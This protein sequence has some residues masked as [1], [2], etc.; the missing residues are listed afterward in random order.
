MAGQQQHFDGPAP[1]PGWPGLRRGLI[2]GGVLT[3]G[4]YGC[5]YGVALIAVSLTV[6]AVVAAVAIVG[7]ILAAVS[8]ATGKSRT[9]HPGRG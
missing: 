1:V 4:G 5:L 2:G 9:K 3:A 6:L 8:E 7:G